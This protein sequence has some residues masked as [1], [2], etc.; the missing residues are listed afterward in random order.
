MESL[1]DT[2]NESLK[3]CQAVWAEGDAVDL[4]SSQ[5]LVIWSDAGGVGPE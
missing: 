2:L 4:T 1:A 3:S 5:P